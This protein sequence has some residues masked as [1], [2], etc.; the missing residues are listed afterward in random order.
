MAQN[1]T[2]YRMFIAHCGDLPI[3]SYRKADLTS[4]YEV[5]RRLPALYAK[6]AEWRNL[7]LKE[8]AQR[9]QDENIE[10]L[11]M[12]TVKRH[13]SAL[14]RLFSYFRKRG[15]YHGENPAHGFEFPMKGRANEGRKV[16]S[17]DKLEKL[18]SS[19]VFIGCFSEGRRSRPGDLII[20]D[21]KYWLPI[22][23]LFHGNRLEEFAQLRREDVRFEDGIWYFNIT[24]EGERQLKNE[25][26]RRR[27]P[28]HPVALEL[29]FV[30]YVEKTA[31]RPDALVFPLLR[32]GGPDKKL[33]YYFTK[34]FSAYR[35]EIG[36][37]ERG[38][39]YHSFRHGVTTKLY[40][41]EV[42]EALIDELTGHEGQGTSRKVYKKQ[43]PLPVLFK[44]ISAVQWPEVQ[45]A[46]IAHRRVGDIIASAD[47]RSSAY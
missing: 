43:M 36:V 13:F 17:S 19:P 10:R 9:T 40:E 26:S 12:K 38:M 28:I 24:D 44:A 18:F 7:P 2:T 6:K 41:E 15:E 47:P 1:R 32:P 37:Y 34:W 20:K 42:Q 5:L 29:G 11:A 27:V 4:F 22:L 23:G 45:L 33:G 21:E 35:R 31:E 30:E 14:G 46:A 16:W 3:Q 39:D 8:I 25:Q